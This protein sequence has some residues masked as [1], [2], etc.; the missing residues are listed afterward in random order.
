MKIN[1]MKTKL[2]CLAGLAALAV[3]LCISPVATQAAQPQSS[4]QI[5]P[6]ITNLTFVNGQI[7][8]SGYATATIRGRV[9]TSGFANVPVNLSVVPNQTN[10]TVCPVL[11]LTL[12]P[13]NLD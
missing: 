4:L 2:S 7:V 3:G 13:I 6:T 12:G 5:V 8:A 10:T 9:Y 11:N 1:Q